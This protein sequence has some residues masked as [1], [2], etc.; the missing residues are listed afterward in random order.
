[1]LVRELC[2]LVDDVRADCELARSATRMRAPGGG[3][4][5]VVRGDLV[6]EED[7]ARGV[8]VPDAA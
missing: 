8:G 7:R 2:E 5:A 4:V 3:E 6:E 1:M